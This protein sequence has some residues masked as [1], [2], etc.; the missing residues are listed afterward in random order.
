MITI[1][2]GPG[3]SELGAV[4]NQVHTADTVNRVDLAGKLLTVV[5]AVYA[6]AVFARSVYQEIQNRGLCNPASFR[7]LI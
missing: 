1:D 5:T 2:P 6:V 3:E 4:S 7:S